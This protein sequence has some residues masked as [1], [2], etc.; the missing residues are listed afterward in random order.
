MAIPDVSP[1]DQHAVA[2]LGKGIDNECG[3][4]TARAHDPNRSQVGRVLKAGDARQV[5]T[6]ISAPVTQESND[7][8]FKIRH[9]SSPHSS[10]EEDLS[11]HL[12][13]LDHYCPVRGSNLRRFFSYLLTFSSSHLLSFTLPLQGM[14]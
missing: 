3:V 14:P 11:S 6:G 10:E 12:L 9:L 2:A 5:S 8:G 7:S 1:S 4:D 13:S